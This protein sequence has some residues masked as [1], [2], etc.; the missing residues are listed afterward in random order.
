[1]HKKNKY[2]S[3]P[4]I[5]IYYLFIFLASIF[6]CISYFLIEIINPVKMIN[7]DN[8]MNRIS[9]ELHSIAISQ[10]FFIILFYINI[11]LSKT[12][13]NKTKDFLENNETIKTDNERIS[14]ILIKNYLSDFPVINLKTTLFIFI[15][16]FLNI[17]YS[18]MLIVMRI[19]IME[20]LIKFT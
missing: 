19:K 13:F 17:L 10:I 2:I 12:K 20:I 16:S 5:P 18:Y 3:F 8:I 7:Q 9:L 15:L 1:M 14:D 4:K 6:W 11:K